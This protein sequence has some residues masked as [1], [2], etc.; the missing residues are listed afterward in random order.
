MQ[1]F[2][3]SRLL[4]VIVFIFFLFFRLLFYTFLVS[5]S[6][7]KLQVV[8]IALGFSCTVF[9]LFLISCI[10][11]NQLTKLSIHELWQETAVYMQ[12]YKR[13]QQLINYFNTQPR[14]RNEIKVKNQDPTDS[15]E[16]LQA[17]LKFI[18][19]FLRFFLCRHKTAL[20]LN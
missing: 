16:N 1:I 8:V 19:T 2:L 5:E 15:Y 14:E 13:L 7:L 18:H 9:S 11:C 4:V 6:F 20:N 12:F 17:F 3:L 10:L